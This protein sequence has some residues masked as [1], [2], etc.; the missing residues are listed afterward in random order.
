MYS[1][2]R[3]KAILLLFCLWAGLTAMAV[4]AHTG[5]RT[6]VQSNG[7]AITLRMEGDEYLHWAVSRDGYTLLRVGSDW[8][9]AMLDEQGNLMPSQV[10]AS[11][12][13]QRGEEERAFLSSVRPGLRF[14]AAQTS[15]A[16]AKRMERDQVMKGSKRIQSTGAPH[17]LVILVNFT[18]YTF[19]EGNTERWRHQ[20]KDSNYTEYR[21]T[22]SVRDYYHDNSMGVW[23]PQFD[24]LGPV[25]LPHPESYYGTNGTHGSDQR[26]YLMPADAVEILDSEWDVDFSRYDN[27]N[28]GVVDFVHVIYA[29]AGEHVTGDGD[30]LWPHAYYFV[31]PPTLDGRSFHRYSCSSELTA[32]GYG[33][34][35]IDGIGAVCHELAHVFGIPDFYDTDYS[36][37][38]SAV[39]P[40][41]WDIMA[42]GSYNNNS[43]TP[44]YFSSIEREM[45]GWTTPRTLQPGDNTLYP[46]TDSNIALKVHLNSDEYLMLEYRNGRKWDAYVPGTGMLIWHADTSQFINWEN[47][48]DVNADPNDRG[49]Y[50]EPAYGDVE[51]DEA[52]YPGTR[53][54]TSLVYF[55]LTNGDAIPSMLND[56]HYTTDNAIAFD[57]YPTMP[58][59]FETEVEEAALT[60]AT[61]RYQINSD[62]TV[63]NRMVQYRSA[64][65]S[66]YT[67]LP[68]TADTGSIRLDNLTANTTYL[69][70]F[71]ADYTDG[72]TYF[73]QTY[74]MHTAC[75]EGAVDAFPYADGFD[76]G[77]DCWTAENSANAQWE[78][79]NDAIGGSADAVE[80]SRL[81]KFSILEPSTSVANARLVSPMMDIT[82]LEHPYLHFSYVYY[83]GA[84][85]PLSV[86][87]RSSESGAWTLLK[88]YRA[89]NSP[90]WKQ[91][92]V[93]LPNGT[94]TY[95]IS[96]MGRDNQGYG[97]AI[98]GVMVK[99]GQ[100]GV[101]IEEV[102]KGSMLLYPNPANDFVMVNV[103]GTGSHRVSV[104][105]VNGRLAM[106]TM[107]HN[108]SAKLHTNHLAKGMYFVKVGEGKTTQ[109]R[110]FVKK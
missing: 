92:S 108:G 50:I 87:Y 54:V 14:G 74:S 101:G 48:N 25:T 71:C 21:Y 86:Y 90:R 62:S 42:S 80:G 77:I 10:A 46:M 52:P 19:D 97:A 9:Y 40:G 7:K 28:D 64:S 72:T 65:E 76:N 79:D 59:Q 55:H 13:S 84:P 3:H 75:F 20:I 103:E 11:D 44:P 66:N 104:F 85:K 43:K 107:A 102:R 39:T 98:D 24:V 45:M 6:H 12:A 33:G 99:N 22:G 93:A 49:C 109:V 63:S 38:G 82:G 68:L 16:H 35:S 15:K 106:T 37:Q 67:S 57:Y 96:F 27:D 73:S 94:A 83:S 34:S 17:F 81:A 31:N 60:Y 51:S 1:I 47:R 58:I 18:D 36:Q 78:S 53:G 56:I 70:R 29:G 4:P 88:E 89:T 61:I 23:D 95:Q 32:L 26:P 105:D 91:D 69:F 41:T 30:L 2:L 8:H 100:A 110:S 5:W